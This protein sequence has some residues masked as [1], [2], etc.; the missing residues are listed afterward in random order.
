MK[1]CMCTDFKFIR[2][3][4]ISGNDIKF[5]KIVASGNSPVLQGLLNANKRQ[6]KGFFFS[7]IQFSVDDVVWTSMHPLDIYLEAY[8][9]LSGFYEPICQV[10]G[11]DIKTT[12]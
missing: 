1:T 11:M 10:Y 9:L 2:F 5:M 7:V 8:T 3:V 4:P 6:V 12:V